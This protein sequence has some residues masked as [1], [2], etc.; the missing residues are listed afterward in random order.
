[1]EQTLQPQTVQRRRF[2]FHQHQKLKDN[3]P[4]GNK[5]KRLSNELCA[6]R[7]RQD[8][9]AQLPDVKGTDD[10][11]PNEA[12]EHAEDEELAALRLAFSEAIA[13]L[14]VGIFSRALTK[15]EGKGPV[16]DQ[17]RILEMI[18]GKGRAKARDKGGAD[19]AS[20]I[21]KAREMAGN[22]AATEVPSVS[23][24]ADEKKDGG[25]GKQHRA[26]VRPE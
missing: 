6:K 24:R 4:N 15:Q 18:Q 16:I 3:D 20:E 11:R 25:R 13:N 2:N 7:Q 22:S 9:E 10:E 21:A 23:R 17:D 26:R 1:M 8:K 12:P 14:T 5:Q 19:E